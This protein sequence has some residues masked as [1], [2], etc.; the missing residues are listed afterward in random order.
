MHSLPPRESIDEHKDLLR[1]RRAGRR[2]A[3]GEDGSRP[4]RFERRLTRE[5]FSV[6]SSGFGS[7]DL[8]ASSSVSH[9]WRGDERGRTREDA[10]ED[11]LGNYR[12]GIASVVF[13]WRSGERTVSQTLDELSDALCSPLARRRTNRSR[14]VIQHPISPLTA[15]SAE[16]DS[17]VASLKVVAYTRRISLHGRERRARAYLERRRRRSLAFPT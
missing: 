10:M 7:S 12:D 9:A 6:D 4:V 13:A 8:C 3:V 16:R 15:T 17:H 2:A 11:D 1:N 5:L 14:T